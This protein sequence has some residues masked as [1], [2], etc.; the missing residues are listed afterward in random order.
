MT[1]YD[2]LFDAMAPDDSVFA[3][4][5]VLDPLA[6][7]DE[8]VARDAQEEQLACLLNGLHEGYLP[9]SVSIYGPPGTGKIL[10]TRRVCREFAVRT[11]MFEY[12]N[13]KQCRTLFSAANEILLALTGEQK[14]AYVC[15]DG[16][17]GS[18][19]DALADYPK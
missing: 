7:P 11:E 17:F 13:L 5:G 9:A 19:W 1:D 12:V 6:E 10:T 8:V 4:K 15:L 18:I 2:D 14:Q 3:D 16:I